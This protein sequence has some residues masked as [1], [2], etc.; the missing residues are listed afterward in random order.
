MTLLMLSLTANAAMID[1][2]SMSTWK[3]RPYNNPDSIQIGYDI[4]VK[5]LAMTIG[6]R[7]VGGP[8]GGFFGLETR[9]SN[10]FAF[11]DA[12]VYEDGAPSPWTLASPS[13]TAPQVLWLPKIEFQKGLPLSFDIGVSA[14]LIGSALNPNNLEDSSGNIGSGSFGSWLRYTPL[15]GVPNLPELSF[16]AGYTGYVGNSN[17][18]LGVMDLSVVVSKAFAFGYLN[19]INSAHIIPYISAGTHWVQADPHL[20]DMEQEKMGIGPISGFMGAENYTEGYRLFNTDFGFRL[21][22]NEFLVQ[23]GA[24]VAPS[25][26]IQV[27]STI[28]LRY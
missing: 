8:S 18:S 9:L 12:R 15:E 4:L 16:Q 6:N 25:A 3:N 1:P 13:E 2:G 23:L 24:S 22:N 28:G 14:G 26:L 11:I 20:T 10:T 27:Q 5:E 21:Q 7:A 19:G 17:L